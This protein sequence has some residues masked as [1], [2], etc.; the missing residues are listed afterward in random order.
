MLRLNLH[1]VLCRKRSEQR[2]GAV[3]RSQG[4]H[5]EAGTYLL[6]QTADVSIS[7]DMRETP[8][9]HALPRWPWQTGRHPHRRARAAGGPPI[10]ATPRLS[11]S[12]RFSI[13]P[14]VCVPSSVHQPTSHD[15]PTA[16]DTAPYCRAR[17][18]AEAQGTPLEFGA[19]PPPPPTGTT[20][21]WGIA[22]RRR[23]RMRRESR[24]PQAGRRAR[25]RAPTARSAHACGA[26]RRLPFKDRRC[27]LVALAP[28]RRHRRARARRNGDGRRGEGWRKAQGSTLCRLMPSRTRQTPSAPQTWRRGCLSMPPGRD[29]RALAS[30]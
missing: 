5:V 11:T 10:G 22:P 19:S 25:L 23:R 4:G 8:L 26:R 30:S 18:H 24:D 27:A 28:G 3:D 13:M 15:R 7:D 9:H 20:G 17:R 6:S 12:R 1:R 29:C 21:R 2:D 14:S 16:P